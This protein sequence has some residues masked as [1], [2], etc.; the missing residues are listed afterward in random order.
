MVIL[1]IKFALAPELT[2]VIDAIIAFG[3]LSATASKINCQLDDDDYLDFIL[4]SLFSS[5]DCDGNGLYKSSCAVPV[6]ILAVLSF[7]EF[8]VYVFV[9]CTIS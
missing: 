3:C 4:E 5:F 8:I 1:V 9:C 7:V 2:F 6:H